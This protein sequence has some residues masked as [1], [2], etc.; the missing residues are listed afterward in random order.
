MVWISVRSHL[1]FPSLSYNLI[2]VVTL[3]GENHFKLNT[4]FKQVNTFQTSF[5]AF[6]C[7][8]WSN[9]IF[10]GEKLPFSMYVPV[11]VEK[12]S[13]ESLVNEENEQ[14]VQQTFYWLFCLSMKPKPDK[15]GKALFLKLLTSQTSL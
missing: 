9:N 15:A 10:W 6:F 2:F 14:N 1:L 7:Y 13:R 5:I 11:D 8:N 4:N 12:R 3:H